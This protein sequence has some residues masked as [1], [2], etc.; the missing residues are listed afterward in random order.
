MLP[1]GFYQTGS[2]VERTR[3]E[4]VRDV[5]PGCS[6]ESRCSVARS[7][8]GR[9]LLRREWHNGYDVSLVPLTSEWLVRFSLHYNESLLWCC[10]RFHRWLR[11]PLPGLHRAERCEKPHRKTTIQG[12]TKLADRCHV[13]SL[14]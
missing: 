1:S 3:G 8:A 13:F 7:S 2:D 5:V 6:E 10:R 12:K 4:G 11:S 9:L 14:S